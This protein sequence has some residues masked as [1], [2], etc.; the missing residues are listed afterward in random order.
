VSRDSLRLRLF[1]AGAA[2]VAVTLAV[3]ALGLA[4]LFERHV[5]RRAIAELSARLDQ[6]AA[7][8]DSGGDGAVLTRPPTDP[9]YER[10]L[11]GAYWQVRTASDTLRSRSLWDQALALPPRSPGGR[12]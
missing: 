9:R 3:A 7:G 11:S 1:L 5:E 10:P 12:T 4:L 8:L 6:L 2:A